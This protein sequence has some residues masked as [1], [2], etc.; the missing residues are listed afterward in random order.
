MQL[1]FNFSDYP[2]IEK[3]K[4][5]VLVRIKLKGQSQWR[6]GMFYMNGT[7]PTFSSYGTDIS[8][9]VEEWSYK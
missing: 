4:S 2:E 1:E 3:T 6:D 7:K 5:F 9:K 8:N